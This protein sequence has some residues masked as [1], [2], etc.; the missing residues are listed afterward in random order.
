MV[1]DDVCANDNESLPEKNNRRKSELS[2]NIKH[3]EC[4]FATNAKE[5]LTTTTTTT[6]SISKD[7][8]ESTKETDNQSHEDVLDLEEILNI[9]HPLEK[10][11]EVGIEDK[12]D[13]VKDEKAEDVP[14]E[15]CETE[16]QNGSDKVKEGDEQSNKTSGDQIDHI[17]G[18]INHIHRFDLF[19]N[20][21]SRR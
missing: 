2:E 19:L 4:I 21:S 14:A 12:T 3:L 10:N 13:F 8:L 11:E 7:E 9:E 16:S 18:N 17:T 5:T 1:Q 6:T 20:Y 15:K